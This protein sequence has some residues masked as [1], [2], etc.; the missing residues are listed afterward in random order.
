MRPKSPPQAPEPD[1]R[2]PGVECGDTLVFQHPQR[3]PTA[4][5]VLAQ[6]RHGVTGVCP[7]GDRFR[8]RWKHILGHKERVQRRF[9]VV[10]HGEDGVIVRDQDGVRRWLHNAP[11][12]TNGRSGETQTRSRETKEPPMTKSQPSTA[13]IE[14]GNYPKKHIRFQGL[15]ISIE[16]PKGSTRSGTDRGGKAWKTT[17]HHDYG[18]IRSGQASASYKRAVQ[19]CITDI[20]ELGD[21]P[22]THP[23][24]AH[25]IN[26]TP[27]VS[28]FASAIDHIQRVIFDRL[29]DRGF[30]DTYS[31]CDSR[32]SNA[33]GKHL[34]GHINIPSMEPS[35]S[36][37]TLVLQASSDC[38]SAYS[39]FFGDIGNGLFVLS[40]GF[41]GLDINRQSVVQGNMLSCLKNLEIF[42]AII[43]LVPIGVVNVLFDGQLSTDSILDNKAVLL[44]RLS[45][46][47]EDPVWIRS[48]I[49]IDAVASYL[50]IAFA[51]RVAKKAAV[52]CE[53]T[54]SPIK[55]VAAEI[56]KHDRHVLS[57]FKPKTYYSTIG[58]DGDHV[59]CYIGPDPEATTAYI[60]HQRKAGQWDQY[61][62]D[63]VMLGFPNQAAATAAYLQHYDDPRFLGPIT[64]MP[65]DEFKRKALATAAKPAMI[66]GKVLFLKSTVRG[67]IRRLASGK[68]VT[69]Q[70]YQDKRTKKG[71]PAASGDLFAERD[72]EP[73]PNPRRTLDETS[74]N[75][76]RVS[77]EPSPTTQPPGKEPEPTP[78]KPAPKPASNPFVNQTIAQSLQGKAEDYWLGELVRDDDVRLDAKVMRWTAATQGNFGMAIYENGKMT[79]SARFPSLTWNTTNQQAA[80][81]LVD[82][83]NANGKENQRLNLR[84]EKIGERHASEQEQAA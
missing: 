35:A 10:D 76:R 41:D 67:H 28:V 82:Y 69:V 2:Y 73:T 23:V 83:L 65:M 80:R 74:T 13:Q 12:E 15:A 84:M 44:D 61:D 75:P 33:I 55:T 8:V 27:I 17:M 71:D 45:A 59:D 16:N 77:D 52:F 7:L 48:G 49:F 21:S 1:P 32:L 22:D 34:G 14:A 53:L 6:G 38:C 57:S 42:R 9:E 70:P 62:E 43:E 19:R 40:H 3:G 46:S 4:L 78:P 79:W 58:V 81:M 11:S 66:K 39:E 60:V 56:A 25:G 5:K 51:S 54:S 50:P 68:M 29:S 26:Y 31:S 18:Y 72:P 24:F 20:D 63:K 47:L 64:A 37:N 36:V 30:R